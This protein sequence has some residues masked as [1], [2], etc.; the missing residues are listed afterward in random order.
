MKPESGLWDFLR[1]R[2]PVGG[3]YTRIESNETAPGFPD[4]HYTLKGVTGGMELK[5]NPF[6]IGDYPFAGEKHGLRKSQR[7]W[8]RDEV[9]CG[10]KVI[11]ALQARH[12]VY[13][14]DGSYWDDIGSWTIKDLQEKA[15][16]IWERDG[17][18]NIAGLAGMMTNL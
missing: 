11:L 7:I 9:E 16:I 4:V 6:P 18:I 14:V 15:D 8:I 2:M 17:N 1:Q 13:F 3:H 5:C 12:H 10:G